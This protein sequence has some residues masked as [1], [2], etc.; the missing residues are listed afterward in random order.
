MSAN[1]REAAGNSSKME[2][3]LVVVVDWGA[4]ASVGGGVGRRGVFE[5]AG[6][7]CQQAGGVG[8]WVSAD[9]GC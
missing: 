7:R 9:R 8:A 1:K 4:G 5:L 2:Y 6:G 3:V